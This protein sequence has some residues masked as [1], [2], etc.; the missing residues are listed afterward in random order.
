[1]WTREKHASWRFGL[2]VL[3]SQI[4]QFL[5]IFRW[6]SRSCGDETKR[7]REKCSQ[8]REKKSFKLGKLELI[9]GSGDFS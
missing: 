9:V 4:R 6:V 2:M 3:F 5:G 8:I 1:M 7:E